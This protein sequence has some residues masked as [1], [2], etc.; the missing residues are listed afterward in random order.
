M[1]K[2]DA[3]ATMHSVTDELYSHPLHCSICKQLASAR[4]IK[5]DAKAISLTKGMRVR[6]EGP[7]LISQMITR[8]L[9]E[10]LLVDPLLVCTCDQAGCLG[11][12]LDQG[13]ACARRGSTADQPDGH[14]Y[15][16]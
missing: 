7:Q 3:N 9:G 2:C 13:Q 16:G 15:S 5:R 1:I 12:Q 14:S 6:A 11:N 4:V 10:L 8:I